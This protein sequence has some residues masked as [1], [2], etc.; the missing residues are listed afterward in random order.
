[1]NT[2]FVEFSR[3]RIVV[4]DFDL[5]NLHLNAYNEAIFFLTHAHV[6]H[7]RQLHANWMAPIYCTDVTRA[8]I[9][10]RFPDFAHPEYLHAI[11]PGERFA[12]VLP[13]IP[14]SLCVRSP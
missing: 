8:L 13:P 12:V 3:R 4:D 11:T 9:L 10:H 5:Q 14:N 7:L 2:A 6:D 1:M